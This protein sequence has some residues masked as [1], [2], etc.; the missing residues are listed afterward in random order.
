M[1]ATVDVAEVGSGAG[2]IA[3]LDA[4]GLL[5]VGPESA[6]ADPGPAC[7]GQGGSAPTV[8][9]ANAVLGFLPSCLAGGALTLDLDAAR[10]AIDRALAQPLGL[11]VEAA[12]EGIRAVANANM[13]RAIRAVTVE[14]GLDPRDLALLAFGGS[15][16][17]HAGDL[18]GTLGIAV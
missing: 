7:D 17:A 9:D 3:F 12:A 18:A 10:G 16:P 4:A 13:V 11:S 5:T 8:T 14:R 15:G 2:S 1:C 6:G